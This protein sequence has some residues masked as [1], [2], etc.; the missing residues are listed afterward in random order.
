MVDIPVLGL[1]ETSMLTACMMGS[2]FA[3][4]AVNP[5]F[6]ARFS[7]NVAKYGL[8]ERLASIECMGLTPHELD[9]CFSDSGRSAQGGRGIHRGRPRGPGCGRRGHHSGRWPAHC[10]PQ[11]QRHPR[12]RRGRGARWHRDADHA[13]PR[14]LCACGR[15]PGRSSAADCSTPR[16]P[17]GVIADAA[18]DY[19]ASYQMPALAQLAA[20]EAQQ[21]QE[22]G[23]AT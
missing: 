16:R 14:R 13:R 21:V 10:V 11:R 1:G 8:K 15:F 7:E 18:A 20:P 17:R 12:R 22:N 6:S 23:P 19:A 5:Y 4:I 3:L 9:A 2:R